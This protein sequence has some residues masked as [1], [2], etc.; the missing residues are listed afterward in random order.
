MKADKNYRMSKTLKRSLA[1]ST[2]KSKEQRDAWKRAMI[3]AEVVAMAKVK[4]P[5]KKDR[6]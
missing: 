4:M 3:G 6:K 5:D 1:L 2:F